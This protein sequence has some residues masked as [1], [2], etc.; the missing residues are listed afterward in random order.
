M[1]YIEL[2]YVNVNDLEFF[3]SKKLLSNLN[4]CKYVPKKLRP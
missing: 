1:N 4:A 3:Y 2:Q